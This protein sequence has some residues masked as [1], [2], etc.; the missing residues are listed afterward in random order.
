MTDSL[1]SG[2][3]L[4]VSTPQGLNLQGA[5]AT[6]PLVLNSRFTYHPFC[7]GQVTQGSRQVRSPLKLCVF[8]CVFFLIIICLKGD[9]DI[10]RGFFHSL[11]LL[12]LHSGA[13]VCRA[14]AG[15]HPGQVVSLSQ[16]H[17]EKPFT[18]HSLHWPV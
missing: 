13:G 8:L 15:L 10:H 4:S 2:L 18:L 9:I 17:V 14:K 12:F 7:G 6:A 3:R 5:A 11:Q 16:H 1:E